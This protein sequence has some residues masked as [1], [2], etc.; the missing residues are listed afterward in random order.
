MKTILLALCLASALLA[1][2]TAVYTA[3]P[4]MPPPCPQ[5]GLPP[6]PDPGDEYNGGLE[7]VR[8]ADGSWRSLK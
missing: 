8:Y 7:Y 6:G 5:G 2:S 1:A 4:I 3:G